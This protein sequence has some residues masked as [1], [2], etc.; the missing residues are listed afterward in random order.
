MSRIRFEC[1]IEKIPRGIFVEMYVNGEHIGFRNI[2]G[3]TEGLANLGW[4]KKK[5][6]KGYVLYT[7]FNADVEKSVDDKYYLWNVEKMNG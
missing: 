6:R 1:K 7:E 2:G 4:S 3:D 5:T